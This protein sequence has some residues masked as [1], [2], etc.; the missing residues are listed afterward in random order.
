LTTLAAG[1]RRL[2][3]SLRQ[4]LRSNAALVEILMVGAL[5]L[6]AFAYHYLQARGRV[7]PWIFPDELRYAEFA[8]AVAESGLPEVRGEGAVAGALQS[9]LL[10]PAWL[11][12]DVAT[13]FSVSQAINAFIFC[14]AAIPVYLL[15]RGLAGRRLALV[16][17]TASVAIAPALYASTLMQ[18]PIAY[19]VAT[20]VA[21]LSVRL[22]TS[23]SWATLA[24]VAFACVVGVGVRGELAILPL[25]VALAALLDYGFSRLRRR[26]TDPRSALVAG[27]FAVAGCVALIVVYRDSGL[28]SEISKLVADPVN[29]LDAMSASAAAVVIAIWVVPAVA[30]V[31]A[32][33]EIGGAGRERSAFASV[34]AGFLVVFLLYAGVKAASVAFAPL[35]L[36]EERNLIYLEPLALAALAVAWRRVRWRSA[37]AAALVV[38]AVLITAPI[39]DMSI[40]TVLTENLGTSWIHNLVVQDLFA[41]EDVEM[42]I[43]PVL[44]ALALASAAFL[45]RRATSFCALLAVF[46]LLVA[47]GVVL[48]GNEHHVSRDFAG[49]VGPD[50]T[51]LDARAADEDVAVVVTDATTDATDL[52]LLAFWNRSIRF[53]V[54]ADDTGIWGSRVSAHGIG[55]GGTLGVPGARW[56]LAASQLGVVGRADENIPIRGLVLTRTSGPPRAFGRVSGRYGDGWVGEKFTVST[57]LKAFGTVRLVLSAEEGF[58]PRTRLVTTILDGQPLSWPVE[59]GT[60]RTLELPVPPGPWDLY[61]NLAPAEAPFDIDGSPDSR[62]LSLRLGPVSIPGGSRTL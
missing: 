40:S 57:Y 56:V 42:V 29:S 41:L 51:W 50:R 4:L 2:G 14:L 24:L 49:R 11:F 18:E 52:W 22:I 7:T 8:R 58:S 59:L 27:G 30:Y 20:T 54:D 34:L 46:G 43:L 9:Y 48:Y 17:S 31:A 47:W 55:P 25:A 26:R 13:A 45:L 35:A 23:F 36:I 37:A 21:Y 61:F 12:D 39:H 38:V 6:V 15:V 16:A 32:F 60:A 5:V 44:I 33:G 1:T 53:T 28:W 62:R 19:P 3:L 10:A